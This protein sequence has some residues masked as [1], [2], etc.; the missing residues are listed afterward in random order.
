MA[1][2]FAILLGLSALVL[3]A[4]CTASG[5]ASLQSLDEGDLL[6]SGQARFVTSTT[7]FV[8][9][10]REIAG[11]ST[12]ISEGSITVRIRS[13]QGTG[14][15]M[16]IATAEDFERY[17][18]T[19]RREVL[20]Q[21]GYDPLTARRT[22]LGSTD[23]L[24][25]PAESIPWA[26]SVAGDAPLDLTWQAVDGDFVFAILNAD[27]SPGLD[28]TLEFGTKFR[29]QRAFATAG[30]AIGALLVLVGFIALVLAI[31]RRPAPAPGPSP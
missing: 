19:A 22:T 14:L 30:I 13:H 18:G 4:M 27:G 11:R 8:G 15:F 24:P 3:G 7:G 6:L 17:A 9:A 28:V 25:P 20:D 12:G 10:T 1:R 2:F 29:H 23:R 16:G 21:I 31:R 5:Y 26:A